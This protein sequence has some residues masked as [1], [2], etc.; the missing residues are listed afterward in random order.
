[1]G[2]LG[3]DL[4]YFNFMVMQEE[5]EEEEESFGIFFDK[6]F[7]WRLFCKFVVQ[8]YNLWFGEWRDE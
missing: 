8:F 6:Y 7:F 3:F 4:S 2:S 1:M 5:D